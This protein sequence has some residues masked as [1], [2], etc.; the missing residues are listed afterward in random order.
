M[1]DPVEQVENVTAGQELTE[2]LSDHSRESHNESTSE[3]EGSLPQGTPYS[4]YSKRLRSKCI[5]RVAGALGLATGASAAQTRKLI[6]EK[7]IEMDRQPSEVQIIV[8]GTNGDGKIYL[9]D[10]SGIIKSIKGAPKHVSEHAQL[11]GGVRSALR[12]SDSDTRQLRSLLDEQISTV[13]T[14]TAELQTSRRLLEEEKTSGREKDS[15]IETLQNLLAKEKQRVKRHWREKCEQLL[16]HEES[17]EEKEAEIAL[18]K[19]RILSL[20]SRTT[21]V[22]AIETPVTDDGVPQELTAL[23]PRE[24]SRNVTTTRRGKA[25]PVEPYTGEDPNTLWEDW[26]PMFERAASWNGWTEQERLLQLAGHL[27]GKALQEWGLLNNDHKSTF[28]KATTEMRN[29]LD[30]GSK[31]IAVQE[32]RHMAQ[33]SKEQ[34]TDFIR[35]LEQTFRRAYGREQ[36][37]AETRDALLQGQLQEGLRL[38]IVMAPAVSGAKTYQEL[39]IPAKNEERRQ[40]ALSQRQLYR[41]EQ[42]TGYRENRRSGDVPTPR[43]IPGNTRTPEQGPRETKRCYICNG[44]DHLAKQ[45]R[46]FKTES[47][48]DGHK[49]DTQQKPATA[50]KVESD[51]SKDLLDSENLEPSLMDILYSSSDS[52][53]GDVRAIRVQDKG[54]K[55]RCARVLVQGVPAYG[56]IDT[57]ADITIIGGNLFRKVASVARLKKKDLKPADKIPRAYD[58]RPF[59]LDGRMEL[60]ITF[61]EKEIST[62]VYIKVDAADQLLLSEGVSRLL[63]IVEYHP[64]VEVWRGGRKKTSGTSPARTDHISLPSVRVTLVRSVRILPNQSTVIP[65]EAEGMKGVSDIWLLE[66]DDSEVVQVE[67]SFITLQSDGRTQA[68]LTNITGFTQTLPAGTEVGTVSQCE[69]VKPN[70]VNPQ[71]DNSKARVNKVISQDS[72]DS[73]IE[74]LRMW[75]SE[76]TNMPNSSERKK[77]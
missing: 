51:S 26:L 68:V 48:G 6:E 8:Q 20:T 45:C 17:L 12:E 5:Q 67:R 55:P 73:R 72:I 32:F 18:L 13:E 34:V 77:T 27:R 37:T 61:G 39:C 46:A 16:A 11:D 60:V 2:Q 38:T 19:A 76:G 35:R 66:P 23:S 9:V 22:Q 62:Q 36:I 25:P 24:I 74:K 33:K 3:D 63:G 1:G 42:T 70:A 57:A 50:K 53:S 52:D 69:E 56:I 30:P 14:L 15:E 21:E 58:Q 64:D 40:L 71:A 43:F 28:A 10:E 65:I 4:L 41:Q 75:I 29:R 31:M 7:L 47:K 44:Q 49:R 54:S 59:T